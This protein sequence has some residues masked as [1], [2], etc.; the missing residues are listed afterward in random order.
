[1]QLFE[2]AEGGAEVIQGEGPAGMA[3]QLN[4]LPGRQVREDLFASFRDLPFDRRDLLVK[5][6]AEAMILAM[7]VELFQLPLQFG[8]RLL[9]IE[10]MFHSPR[11]LEP[12]RPRATLNSGRPARAVLGKPME[13]R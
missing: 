6:D 11:S 1:M 4:P 13:D 2:L 9:E 5:I 10:L 12:P 7:L 8:N 3:G